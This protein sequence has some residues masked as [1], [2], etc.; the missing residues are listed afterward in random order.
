MKTNPAGPTNLRPAAT[1]KE[2]APKKGT[3]AKMMG[4]KAEVQST[5]TLALSPLPGSTQNQS[6]ETKEV[7]S[8]ALPKELDGLVSEIQVAMQGKESEDVRIQFDS[9]TLAGLHVRLSKENG[10]LSVEFTSKSAE[11]SRM[12]TQSSDMLAQ[13][14]ESHGYVGATVEVRSANDPRVANPLFDQRRSFDQ[15]QSGQQGDR[16]RGQKK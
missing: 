6:I 11:V 1:V 16:Q 9:K 4:D 5:P 3:F 14:L 10:R 2:T 12:L 7:H 13:R 8:V 15:Q